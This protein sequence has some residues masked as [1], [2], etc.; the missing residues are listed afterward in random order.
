ML[1]SEHAVHFAGGAPPHFLLNL[2]HIRVRTYLARGA[3]TQPFFENSIQSTVK[4]LFLRLRFLTARMRCG[5]RRQ[6]AVVELLF[7]PLLFEHA[8]YGLWM[9]HQLP[10]QCLSYCCVA[11][12]NG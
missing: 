2:K 12:A 7:L 5:G 10:N 6:H 1:L 11:W 4:M 3:N 9:R 8:I